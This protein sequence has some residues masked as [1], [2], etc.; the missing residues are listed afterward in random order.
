MAEITAAAV[1]ALRERTG[2]PMMECKNALKESAGD[3]MLAIE[4]LRKQGHKTMEKRSGRETAFGRM[5]VF[6]SLERRVG[7]MV[8]LKCESAPVAQNE[9]FIQLANDLARQLA[10]GPGAES[11]ES[12]LD[13]PSPSK[14]GVSLRQQ[15]DD[16]FN[17]FREIFNIGR[18][19]RLEGP[20][21]SYSH[22]AAEVSGV[23]LEVEGGTADV[24]KD[25]CMHI[26][27]MHPQALTVQELDPQIVAKEREIL[28]EAARKEGRPE[29]ILEKMVDGRMKSFYAESVLMEQAFVR[30]QK[31]TVGRYAQQHGMKLVRFVHWVLGRE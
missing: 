24:A 15:R 7:A 19:V 5:G 13:Q 21:G 26:A 11:A 29:S 31:I 14:A 18:L 4:L 17:R 20:C 27:A 28:S 16:L 30:D 22:N 10:Q 1:K 25:I 12:L 9:E 2:L 6:A 3:E 23:L 8:E